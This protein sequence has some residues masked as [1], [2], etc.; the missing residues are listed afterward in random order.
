MKIKIDKLVNPVR[1]DK[2]T[3]T[4]QLKVQKAITVTFQRVASGWKVNLRIWIEDANGKHL[5][6]DHD[7]VPEDRKAFDELMD[8]A[9]AAAF[10]NSEAGRRARNQYL[11]EIF[12]HPETKKG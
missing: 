5:V 1:V 7:T 11:P 4:A 8:S 9:E 3:V 12:E 6:H 2:D 10:S